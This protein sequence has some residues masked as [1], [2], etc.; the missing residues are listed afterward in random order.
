MMKNIV[1]TLAST[2]IIFIGNS[3]YAMKAAGEPSSP[4]PVLII[5]NE[6]SLKLVFQY[7][8]QEPGYWFYKSVVPGETVI[9]NRN[10]MDL[11]RLYLYAGD[12][13]I[14][15]TKLASSATAIDGN[16]SD[17]VRKNNNKPVQITVTIPTLSSREMI[18]AVEERFRPF[19]FTFTIPAEVPAITIPENATFDAAFPAVKYSLNQKN[20]SPR[21]V[22]GL[23]KQ[24]LLTP[25]NEDHQYLESVNEAY[26]TL[27]ARWADAGRNYPEKADYIDRVIRTLDLANQAISSKL[28]FQFY[29]AESYNRYKPRMEG[30]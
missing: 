25:G 7:R 4:P 19:Q 15:E 30:K 29:G 14:N 11:K 17:L 12:R 2:L 18:K 13:I 27:K 24:E 20:F 1:F 16:F 22:L 10:P 21:D 8:Q 28:A 23:P 9:I 5:K 3:S 26:N 6:T